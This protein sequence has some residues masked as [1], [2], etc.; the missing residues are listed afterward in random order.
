MSSLETSVDFRSDLFKPFLPE[1]SQVNPN[2][3]GAE[4]TYWL[5]QKLAEKSVITTYPEY[6]DWGWFIEYFVDDNEYRLCCSNS[7]E[8]GGKWYCYLRP[9]AKSL[10]GRN[11]AP[12]ELA[13]PLL[14]AI[15]EI[16]N[17]NN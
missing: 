6:E 12:L 17:E 9:M 13:A 10:F 7:D 3:Y 8:A 2:V 16:L 14:T 15:K 4:L 11:K 1:E 5:S